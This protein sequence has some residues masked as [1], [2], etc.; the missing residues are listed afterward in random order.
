MSTTLAEVASAL[1]HDPFVLIVTE[2]RC[3]SGQNKKRKPDVASN[4]S[5]SNDGGTGDVNNPDVVVVPDN[6]KADVVHLVSGIVSRID[7]LDFISS[8]PDEKEE[9]HKHKVP[10]RNKRRASLFVLGRRIVAS[11]PKLRYW[12]YVVVDSEQ[13]RLAKYF[14]L[15]VRFS[16][17]N[18]VNYPPTFS[19]SRPNPSYPPHKE[20]LQNIHMKLD[21]G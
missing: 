19:S 4:G 21:F 14:Y 20:T 5:S 17:M 13:I 9:K 2:Q 12:F 16:T 15:V 3:Y 18:D 11:L 6:C 10:R 1:D 7:L 8:S